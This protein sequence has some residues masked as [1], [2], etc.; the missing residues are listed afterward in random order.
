[1]TYIL[2]ACHREPLRRVM[3]LWIAVVLNFVAAVLLG[4][5]WL[6]TTIQNRERAST[7]LFALSCIWFVIGFVAIIRAV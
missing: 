6:I 4:L 1:M 5:A 3:N 2:A 7:V